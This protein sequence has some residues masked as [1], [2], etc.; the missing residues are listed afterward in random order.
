MRLV[1]TA[2]LRAGD[3]HGL[4]E[5]EALGITRG[6]EQMLGADAVLLVLDG[7]RMG[8]AGLNACDCPD[9]ATAD[10]LEHAGEVPVIIVWNKCDVCRPAEMPFSWAGDAPCCSVSARTGE[11]L[12]TLTGLLRKTLLDEGSAPV[13]GGLVPNARQAM[14]LE[15]ALAELKALRR[16]LAEGAPCDCCSVRLDSLAAHLA[17]VAGVSSPSEVLDAVFSHFCI[18]K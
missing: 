11:N 17:D 8:E 9:E 12:N 4:D 7:A 2:G 14:A 1:D 15:A 18:G 6:R 5:V 3:A 16:D 10:V 13:E